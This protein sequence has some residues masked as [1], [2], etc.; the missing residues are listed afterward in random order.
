MG[1]Y[2][3]RNIAFPVVDA[4]LVYPDTRYS[5]KKPGRF[6]GAWDGN[7]LF[8]VVHVLELVLDHYSW[9]V[10]SLIGDKRKGRTGYGHIK[11]KLLVTNISY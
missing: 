3:Y 1:L 4:N 5:A 6:Y 2:C 7:V 9:I 11:K 10:F 8:D